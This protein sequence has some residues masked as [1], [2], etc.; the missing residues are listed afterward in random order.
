MVVTEEEEMRRKKMAM[1]SKEEMAEH[2]K[3]KDR[4]V[5]LIKKYEVDLV[6]V[7]ANKLEARLLKQTMEKVADNL[8]SAGA[9]D[10]TS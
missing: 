10:T 6:V 2:L 5:E 4:I 3:D 8:S 9:N 7:G 1:L